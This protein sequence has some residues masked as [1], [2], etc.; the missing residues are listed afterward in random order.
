[1]KKF[2][3]STSKEG[4]IGG[5]AV[6]LGALL[7]LF[8]AIF[9]EANWAGAFIGNLWIAALAFFVLGVGYIL[10]KSGSN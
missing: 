7:F 1:M 8:W 9:G 2:W 5:G 6:A 4:K 10:T 3:A